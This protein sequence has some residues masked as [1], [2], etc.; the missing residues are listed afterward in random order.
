VKANGKEVIVGF[1]DEKLSGAYEKLKVGRFED[2]E[3]FNALKSAIDELKK[4]PEAGIAVPSAL[5]PRIY[6]QKYGISNLRKYDM[7]KGWR[8]VYTIK[9]SEINIIAVMLEWFDSHK[10]YEKR[11]GYRKK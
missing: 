4:N 8:L 11:F 1:I 2:R 10:K 6:V 9:T 3:F 5:W 7:Q